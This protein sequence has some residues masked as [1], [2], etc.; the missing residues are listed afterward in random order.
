[1][2]RRRK[3]L[4]A[5][6]ANALAAPL[7]IFAQQEKQSVVVGVLRYGDRPG[8]QVYIDAFKQG[9]QELGYIEGRNLALELRFAEGKAERLPALAEELVQ[10]K[11][12]V[13]LTG[14]TPSARAAQRATSVIPIVMGT[15]TDPVGNGLVA[16]LA[17][18]GGNITGLS[19][20]S[21]DISPKRLEML[22]AVV[23]KLSRVAVLLNPSNPATRTELKSLEA[24]SQRA[25]LKLLA[26]E[27]ETPEQIER[28]FAA[29]VKQRAQGVV[30]TNDPVFGQ[31]R[32]QIAELALKHRIPCLGALP[33]SADAGLLL[34]YGQNI[35]ENHR[36]A[37]TYVD[38][39]IR[40]AKPADLPVEQPTKIEL[41]INMKTAKALGIR[42]PNSIL[43]RADKVIE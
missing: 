42:I 23:P 8:G 16:S 33:A 2:N 25:K 7:L 40:G 34:S 18:P 11:V 17:H 22:I 30:M 27:A 29:M 19:N 20:M 36:R 24:A 38:R 15:A 43:V 35:V 14:D 32:H 28:A 12:D 4:V 3:L 5:L 1:V 10:L 21:G 31:Q 37:A 9:L 6:G 39:I 26:L 13:I 41:V